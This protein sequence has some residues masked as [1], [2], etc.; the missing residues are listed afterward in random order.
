MSITGEEDESPIKDDKTFDDFEASTYCQA[1]PYACFTQVKLDKFRLEVDHLYEV[2]N[3]TYHKFL[4]TIDHIDFHP[5]Q[6]N[7][8]CN[9]HSQSF[10]HHGYYE[11][12]PH[13]LMEHEEKFLDA[14]LEAMYKINPELHSELRHMK[15]FGLMTWILGWGVISN[16]QSINKIKKNLRILQDQNVLQDHQIKALAKHLNLTMTQVNRHEEMLYELDSKLLILNCTIQ[17]I[18]VQL[19]YF[20]YEYTIMT[21]IQM[22]INRIYTS[23][24]ALKEDVDALYEYM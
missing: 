6:V 15:C 13:T 20:R 7:H 21:H 16:A 14:F 5:T 22:R 24:F 18:M 19:S 9:K 4:T 3:L 23:I 17:D 10:Q 2:F 11:G 12:A 1:R 8:T